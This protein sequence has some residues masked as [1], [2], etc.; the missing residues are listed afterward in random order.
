MTAAAPAERPLDDAE[1][2]RRIGER[3]ERAFEAVM[4]AHNRLLYRL[5]RSILRDDAE[6]EDAVQDAYLAAYRNIARFRGGA[7]LSTWLARIVINEAYGRLRRHRRGGI[8]VALG[9]AGARDEPHIEEE[10]MADDHAEQPDTAAMRAELRRLLERQI[11][12]L[13][14]QFR[15][16]FVLRDVE[17]MSVEEASECLDIPPATVRSRAFRARAL[18]REALSRE[19]DTAAVD[20]FGFAGARCDRIVA[21]VLERMRTSARGGGPHGSPR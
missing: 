19:I 8:V 5:A 9:A 15:T 6:A 18:L 2:A 17:E 4:R 13:P 20:A 3:D 21:N 12:A 1:L 14:E 7:K 16:V 10:A 11:D